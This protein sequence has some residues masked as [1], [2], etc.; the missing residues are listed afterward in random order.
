MQHLLSEYN[1]CNSLTQYTA[2][3][4]EIIDINVDALDE[5]DY[6]TVSFVRLSDGTSFSPG[7]QTSVRDYTLIINYG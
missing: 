1:C 5:L 7:K 6:E 4:G 3:P 2:Y